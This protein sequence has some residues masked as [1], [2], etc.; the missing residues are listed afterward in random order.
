[1]ASYGK[2]RIENVKIEEVNHKVADEYS[3]DIFLFPTEAQ[4]HFFE[5]HPPPPWH[6]L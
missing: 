3:H 1:M 6:H 5:G 4:N 2:S